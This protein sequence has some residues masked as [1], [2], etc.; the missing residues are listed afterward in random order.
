MSILPEHS[1]FRNENRPSPSVLAAEISAFEY[2]VSS[3]MS[4]ER[5]NNLKREMEV[6]FC[7]IQISHFFSSADCTKHRGAD[8]I[9]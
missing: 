3:G 7:R 8:K 6:N 1:D 2:V 4:L 5:S 9:L